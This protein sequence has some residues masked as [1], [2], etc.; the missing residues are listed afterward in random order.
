ML[1]AQP[2]SINTELER[3]GYE[4][5]DPN[6]RNA[7]DASSGPSSR[8][9]QSAAGA[10]A[11]RTVIHQFVGADGNGPYAVFQNTNGPFYG[12]TSAGGTD[13]LGTLFDVSVG[14]KP[15]VE[16]LPTYGKVGKTIDILGQG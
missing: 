12:A 4:I 7:P 10:P 16:L 14:L 2:L 8:A 15:F 9:G 3:I 1:S 11:S 5:L 6:P 13:N